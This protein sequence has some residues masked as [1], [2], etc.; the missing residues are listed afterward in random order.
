MSTRLNSAFANSIHHRFRFNRRTA[1]AVNVVTLPS[2]F[3]AANAAWITAQSSSLTRPSFRPGCGLPAPRSVGGRPRFICSPLML[4]NLRQPARRTIERQGRD[5]QP[6]TDQ[7][8]RNVALRRQPI[9]S[10]NQPDHACQLPVVSLPRLARIGRS[11]AN[12]SRSAEQFQSFSFSCPFVFGV[13]FNPQKEYRRW[14]LLCPQQS[15]RI[16]NKMKRSWRT[17]RSTGAGD[18]AGSRGKVA[19]ARPVTFPFMRNR[20][21]AFSSQSTAFEDHAVFALVS[22]RTSHRFVAGLSRNTVCLP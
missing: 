1:H 16:P 20:W 21:L 19:R 7:P 8:M 4:G 14:P 11:V 22:V 13:S 3:S 15:G 18:N 17:K 9:A 5:R 6:H 2:A 10:R 12:F